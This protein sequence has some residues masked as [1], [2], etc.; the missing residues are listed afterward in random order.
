LQPIFDAAI[1]SDIDSPPEME[2]I[3]MA[4]EWMAQESAYNEIRPL[5]AMTALEHLID[6]HLCE[7]DKKVM[8]SNAFSPIRLALSAALRAASTVNNQTEL[9]EIER[10]LADLNR[11]SLSRKLD[12]LV[13]RWGVPLEDIGWK[14]VR[15]AVQARNRVVHTG[16]HRDASLWPQVAVMRELM[17]RVILTALRFE[18]RYVTYFDGARHTSFPPPLA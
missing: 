5:S 16:D 2:G 15:D 4:I 17:V 6:T 8:P 18:G 3:G 14:R 9:D 1:R 11:R 13:K 7:D 12:V 10:K